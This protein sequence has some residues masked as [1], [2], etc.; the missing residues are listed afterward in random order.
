M[1]AWVL[2]ASRVA[3]TLVLSKARRIFGNPIS[4]IIPMRATTVIIS[5]SVKPDLRM[6]GL[7]RDSSYHT[8]CRG[9]NRCE[10]ITY[11]DGGTKRGLHLIARV[12]TTALLDA[13][14]IHLV[15]QGPEAHPQPLGGRAPIAS[16]RPQGRGDRLALRSLDDL[17]ERSSLLPLVPRGEGRGKRS[18]PEVGRLQDLLI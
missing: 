2:S 14:A 12:Q 4:T 10:T 1:A 18:Y 6:E 7:L 17:T 13:V 11:V 16:R 9:A 15:E 5:M 8:P 3:R